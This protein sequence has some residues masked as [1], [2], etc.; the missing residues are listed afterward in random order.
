M[1]NLLNIKS[2]F[3]FLNRNKAYTA[4]DVFGLSVSLMFVILIATYVAGELS[5]DRYHE[6]VDRIYVL[7]N[8][9]YTGSAW[10]V[11]YRLEERYP[12]VE[13]V[14]HVITRVFDGT[15]LQKG[16]VNLTANL[17]LA[18]TT[19]FDFLI[20]HWLKVIKSRHWWQKTLL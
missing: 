8:G 14:C 2:F 4:I 6:N 10:Q 5:T 9:E 1:N 20:F 18:D 16:D 19:F 13:K 3:K 17:M 7:G 15:P 12:E 11:G